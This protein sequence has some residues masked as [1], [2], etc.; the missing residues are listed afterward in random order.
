MLYDALQVDLL[1]D[2][3]QEKV[4]KVDWDIVDNNEDFM[5]I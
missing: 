4:S 3:E 1:K 2:S 5:K